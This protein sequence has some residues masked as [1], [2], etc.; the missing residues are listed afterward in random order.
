M[1]KSEENLRQFRTRFGAI[2]TI[3]AVLA[4]IVGVQVW[5]LYHT[6]PPFQNLLRAEMA[7]PLNTFN[8]SPVNPADR[9]MIV[10]TGSGSRVQLDTKL[11][12]T[13]IAAYWCPHCQRTLV[14][15]D[16]YQKTLK[17]LPI[18][19]STGFAQGTTLAEA[20]RLTAQETAAL[21]LR[22]FRV[23]YLLHN[24]RASVTEFPTLMFLRDGRWMQLYGEHTIA[25]WRKAIGR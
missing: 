20:K 11:L 25:V 3:I 14:L 1:G 8:A 7:T 17:R 15:L 16:H 5:R 24:W 18:V 2:F 22:G 19:I 10:V 12:P 23:Y 6:N 4:G 9:R 13:V 21:H